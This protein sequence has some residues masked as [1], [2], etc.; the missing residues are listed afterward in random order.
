MKNKSFLALAALCWCSCSTP[1]PSPPVQALVDAAADAPTADVLAADVASGPDCHWAGLGDPPDLSIPCDL[2]STRGDDCRC[3]NANPPLPGSGAPVGARLGV[4]GFLPLGSDAD[5]AARRKVYAGLMHDLG[6]T[7]LRQEIRW[8]M[9]E[10]NQGQFDWTAADILV[11]TAKAEQWRL[12]G[13]LGYGNLWAS[14]LGK[15]QNDYDF[16]PDDPNDF[17][18]YAAAVAGRYKADA[19]DWEIWNEQNSGWRFWKNANGDAAGDPKGYADL[20]LPT[21]AAI[22]K[23]NPAAHVAYG[24]LFY[25]PQFIP[26]AE[27]FFSASLAARPQLAQAFDALAYH[28]YSLYPP[29][30]PPEFSTPPGQPGIA[31]YAADETAR[32]LQ[33]LIVSDAKTPRPLWVTEVGWPADDGI[34]DLAPVSETQQA[35]YL[36]RTAL[37]LIS[38]NVEFVCWYT[39]MD[40]PP[41]A[42]NPVPWERSFGL[43]RWDADPNDGKPPEPKPAGL[44]HA[45]LAQ[46]LGKLLFS[47]DEAKA[48]LTTAPQQ[49]AFTSA[50]AKE[51]VHVAWNWQAQ[52]DETQPAWFHARKGYGYQATDMWGKPIGVTMHADTRVEF[53]VGRAPVYVHE[54]QS[55]P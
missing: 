22:H 39:V 40:M 16:P 1:V 49:L 11:A 42:D 46:T 48:G 9:V 38:A 33:Q 53:P 19:Q 50:D 13:L 20:L 55:Q 21:Y 4:S 51:I 28:P 12:I 15:S 6:A 2:A 41:A 32:R 8:D 25:L 29:I 35:Q 30:N 27:A 43:Y 47:Q 18:T 54:I 10:P 5:S 24:G 26:G 52:G 34:E 44:A 36:V 14:K 31:R 3:W 7:V 37:L 23:E 17:A 45:A